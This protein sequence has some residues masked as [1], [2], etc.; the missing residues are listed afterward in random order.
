M[1]TTPIDNV[2]EVAHKVTAK[3]EATVATYVTLRR[4]VQKMLRETAKAVRDFCLSDF[5]TG[6]SMLDNDIV[7]PVVKGLYRAGFDDITTSEKDGKIYMHVRTDDSKADVG[8][9]IADI[10]ASLK[11]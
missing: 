1:K 11:G 8:A 3:Y 5:L 4:S 10:V 6:D 9:L 7:T 2:A